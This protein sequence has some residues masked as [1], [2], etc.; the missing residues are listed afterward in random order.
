MKRFVVVGLGIF[1][2]GVT[3]T[4]VN[5]GHEVIA[6]DLNEEKVD[7]MATVATR[8]I[9]G[10]GQ[11]VDVLRRIGAEGADAGIVST[12]DDISSSI[13]AT[14]ALRDCRVMEIYVKVVSRDHARVMRRLGVT[15]TVFP[16]RESAI[17]LATRV[18]QGETLLKY[19]RLG[20]GFSLQEMVVPDEWE[21]KPLRS[22]NL[23]ARYNITVV[24]IHDILTDK[25][26][27]VPDPD[28]PLKDSDTLLIVG[29]DRAL[30]RV[31]GLK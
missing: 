1:G 16:E 29:T 13:L 24:A 19:L 7:R 4:L 21:G 10:D 31:A 3:E 27:P 9:L 2:S 18:A 17:N 6:I 25:I 26:H 14:M 30:A 8:A 23:R 12:G 15:E 5:Q 28:S 11:Q 22:L 20:D